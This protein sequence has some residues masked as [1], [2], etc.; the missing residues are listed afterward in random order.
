MMFD[1][2]P[3]GASRRYRFRVPDSSAPGGFKPLDGYAITGE[4]RDAPDALPLSIPGDLEA[5][6]HVAYVDLKPA[7]TAT[8]GRFYLDLKAVL[9]DAV[10]IGTVRID[11]ANR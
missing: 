8:P 9:G 1:T 7:R 10:H 2:L 3:E 4:M 11:I 5:D 6:T